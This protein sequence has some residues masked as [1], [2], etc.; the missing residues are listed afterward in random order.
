[1]QAGTCFPLEWTV[2]PHTFYAAPDMFRWFLNQSSSTGSDWLILPPSGHLYAYPAMLADADQ[3]AFVGQTERDCE[4]L[5]TSGTVSIDKP[6]WFR[7]AAL[8]KNVLN[9]GKLVLLSHFLRD[10]VE[11]LH[12]QIVDG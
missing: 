1:M 8:V 3:E 7:I 6:E 9:F 10:P 2:S 12:T 4:L 5:N 11:S